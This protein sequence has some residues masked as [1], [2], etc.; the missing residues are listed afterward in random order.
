M[1]S[2][3]YWSVIFASA[4]NFF[5]S[6]WGGVGEMWARCGRDLC[7]RRY[8]RDMRR[9]EGDIG[10]RGGIWGHLRVAAR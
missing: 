3:L 7:A 10:E 5:R 8:G 4:M 2:P 1:S 6:A 9:R